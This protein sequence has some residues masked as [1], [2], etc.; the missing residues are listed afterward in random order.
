MKKFDVG[1]MGGGLAGLTAAIHLSQKGLKTTV[2]EKQQYP[3][4]KV[5]GE[6]VSNEVLPYLNN[7]KIDIAGLQPAKIDRLQ[8]GTLAGE[9]LDLQLPLGGLGISRFC[10]DHFLYQKAKENGVQ[11]ECCTVENVVF[12]NNNFQIATNHPETFETKIAIG[13]YGKRSGLDKQLKRKFIAQKSPW[14]AVKMHFENNRFPSNVVALQHFD[15]G[16][17]GL[18]KTETGAV[19]FCYLASYENFRKHKTPPPLLQ[20]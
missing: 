3:F 10:L 12:S 20:A 2:F 7:L 6:Y 14:L 17:C 15:G 9:S 5:C 13:A 8:F 1:I 11:F 4:H 19:N 16:Y 18:S